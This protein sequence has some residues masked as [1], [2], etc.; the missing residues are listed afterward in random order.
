MV[1]LLWLIAAGTLAI[2]APPANPTVGETA[3]LLPSDTPVHA[4]LDELAKHFGDKSALSNVVVVFERTDGPLTAADLQD[5]ETLAGS[6]G[7]STPSES[8]AEE[9]RSA[10]IR[11]PASLAIAGTA[12]PMISDD[13]HAALIT[14]SLPFNFISKQAARVAK[15]VQDAVAHHTGPV[16]L[17]AVVTGSAGYGY[18][19]A[20]ATE[21]SHHKTLIVT[22]ISVILILLL[23]YRAPVAAAVPLVAISLA[24]AV[25][26]KLLAI[27][28]PFGLHGGTAE[29]IFTFVLL[30]GAGVDYSLLFMSRYREG[31]NEGRSPRDAVIHGL[32]TSIGAIASSATMTVSGLVMLCFARF[33]VFRFAGPSVVL[34]LI[35]AAMAAATLVPA[36][37]AIIGP[38]SFWPARAK[39]SVGK[40]RHQRFWPGL[41]ELV[42]RRPAVVMI[43]TLCALVFPAIR[44][45]HIVWDYNSLYSLKSSYP[46]P[47]G[48]AM[49]C[50][51]WPIGET[52]PITILAVA[53]APQI[54]AEWSAVA[55]RMTQSLRP[56]PHIANIRSIAAPLGLWATP[57]QSATLQLL[58][59]DRINSEYLSY[60]RQAMRLS[61]V[62]KE[63][64]LTLDAMD[65]AVQI[66]VAAQTAMTAAGVSGRVMLTGATAEMI[67]MRQITQSDFRRVTTL[68]VLAI[69]I[70]VFLILRDFWLS[71]FILLTTA[72]TYFTTLGITWWVFKL[73][74][75]SGLEWKLQMLLF[76]V[77]VAVGQDYSIFFAV[78]FAQESY[79]SSPGLI[80]VKRA[81]IFTGPVISS[82]GLIMAATLGSI[83][84]ADI[85]LLVQLG[86]AFVIGMLIDTFVVRPLLLPTFIILTRRTLSKAVFARG[87]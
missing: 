81:I 79:R 48:T 22:L 16:G 45:T 75:A 12:N 37:L 78:R 26:F 61:V 6:L 60:D 14:I 80:A 25:V 62:L 35:V 18:D 57:A 11:T 56:F 28:E 77:L 7:K 84:A 36:M 42:V 52:A 76:I 1:V 27:A 40:S 59:G 65:D 47:Q 69:L 64:P 31:L 55:K 8:V 82:C 5:I 10:S 38:V 87:H 2:C 83:M 86:F 73:T 3:D 44:G 41:A 20:I 32:N 54:R 50:R 66:S 24:A 43:A 46:A 17:S 13:R 68:A 63:T 58:G 21:R 85:S 51:H 23:V 4:A 29:Q 34:A 70:V 19:F 30:Y 74:G 67:D 53:D 39:R 33:S 9:L 15:H 72:I 49:V 71:A